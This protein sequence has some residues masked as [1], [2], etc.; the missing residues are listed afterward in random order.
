MGKQR[1]A[2]R[3]DVGRLKRHKDV[4]LGGKRDG[5]PHTHPADTCGI[6]RSYNQDRRKLHLWSCLAPGQV[7]AV[8]SVTAHAD[9]ASSDIDKCIRG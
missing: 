6:E 1:A 3:P 7:G 4:R 5:V 8:V 2:E 9:Q